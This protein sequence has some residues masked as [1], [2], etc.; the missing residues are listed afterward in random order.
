MDISSDTISTSP[1]ILLIDGFTPFPTPFFHIRRFY[2][3]NGKDIRTVP[4]LLA[5]THDVTTYARHIKSA[6]ARLMR[7]YDSDRIDIIGYSMGGVAC[8]YAMKRLDLANEV[9]TFIAYGSPFNGTLV[10]RHSLATGLCRTLGTQLS[11]GSDFLENLHSDPLPE[12]PRY[13]SLYGT[14]DLICRPQDCILHGAENHPI[15]AGHWTFVF[16]SRIHEIV[17]SHLT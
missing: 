5:V 9:R 10:S 13:V 8:L 14:R 2:R 7:R 6:A 16:D 1:P 4:F 15:T 11:P 17:M 12:G 3:K